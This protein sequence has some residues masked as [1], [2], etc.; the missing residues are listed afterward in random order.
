MINQRDKD[1]KYHG[2]W[3][4]YYTDGGLAWTGE[5]KNGIPHGLFVNYDPSEKILSKGRF[6][7]YKV[8]GFWYERKRNN[9]TL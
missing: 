2:Y 9:K 5:Y 7:G 6:K 8:C 3:E 4:L 1:G